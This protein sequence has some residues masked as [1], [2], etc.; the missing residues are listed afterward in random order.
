M[1]KA[2]D[3]FIG[4]FKPGLTCLDVLMDLFAADGQHSRHDGIRAQAESVIRF[5][6][7][8]AR[9]QHRIGAETEKKPVAAS[10]KAR[11]GV[12]ARVKRKTGR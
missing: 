12:G 8:R 5:D 2:L 6:G 7:S 4:D 11:A 9:R 1:Y 3:V 10:T